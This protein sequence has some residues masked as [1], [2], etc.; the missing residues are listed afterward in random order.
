MS[1]TLVTVITALG[2]VGA[3]AGLVAYAQV[4]KGRWTSS[5]WAFQLT[6]IAAALLMMVV[7]GINGVWPSAAANVAWVV[8]GIQTLLVAHRTRLAEQQAAP[9]V[10]VTTAAGAEHHEAVA[11]DTTV[12]DVDLP[13]VD[14]PLDLADAERAAESVTL[15]GAVPVVVPSVTTETVPVAL[16]VPVVA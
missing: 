13:L 3:A 16:R 2:W 15:T 7:A 8:I 9:A 5:S 4:S 11:P 10:T 14:T 6:N 1:S 12:L